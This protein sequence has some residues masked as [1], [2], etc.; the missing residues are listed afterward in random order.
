MGNDRLVYIGGYT[1]GSN[2][3]GEGITVFGQDAQTGALEP[4]GLAAAT[5]GPSFLAWHP[6][7]RYLY[8]VDESNDGGVAAFA[9]EPSGLLRLLNRESSGGATPC[10][11]TVHPS[12]RFLLSA[13]YTS[14]SVVV[15]PIEPDGVLGERTD[16]VQH[17]GT[18]P[19]ERR[20]S[21]PH[22]HQVRVDLVGE[23]VLAVDLGTDTVYVYRLNSSTGKLELVS[24]GKTEPGAGPRHLAFGTDDRLYVAG[25]LDS[26]VTVFRYYAASGKLERLSTSPASIGTTPDGVRNYPSEIATSPDGRFVYV[27]NRGLDVISVLA[28]EGETVRPV[29]DVPVGGEWPRHFA[30]IGDFLY[31]ANQNSDNVVCFRRDEETGLLATPGTSVA[32]PTPACILAALS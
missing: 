4:L 10:Y 20:Q 13:N 27:A 32:V 6:S 11:V 23:H 9:V 28:V 3:R 5:P 16:L 24:E 2:G 1:A 7:G 30:I 14:G 31:V 12:G 17:T 18:G 8:A 25:E 29:A 21:A 22:A 26:T 15:H 19:D